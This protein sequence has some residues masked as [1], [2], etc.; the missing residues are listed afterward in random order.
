[1]CGTTGRRAP[2]GQ[3][4]MA[5]LPLI[6]IV[7]PV[8]SKSL[9]ETLPFTRTVWPESAPSDSPNEPFSAYSLA[10]TLRVVVQL[11]DPWP[12]PVQ[13]L[14]TSPVANEVARPGTN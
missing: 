1:M 14:T 10:P 7:E 2:S 4:R 11:T 8:G 13:R 3:P 6:A 9:P 12:P 5:G